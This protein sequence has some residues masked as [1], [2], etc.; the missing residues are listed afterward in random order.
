[1]Y[2]VLFIS[3]I[4]WGAIDDSAADTIDFGDV[5]SAVL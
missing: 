5:V 4:D 3:Q 2:I 1:M